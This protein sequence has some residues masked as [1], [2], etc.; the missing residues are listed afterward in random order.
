MQR[1]IGGVEIEGDLAR[2]RPMRLEKQIDEQSVHRLR[3]VADLVVARWFRLR[4]F[5]PVQRRLAGH[6]GAVRAPRPKLPR[7][8]RHQWIVAQRLMVVEVLVAER[9]GEY[10]LPDKRRD[11]MLD[12]GLGSPIDK[13][14][15]QPIHHP[16]RPIR[17]AQQQRPRIRCDRTTV[18][19]RTTWRLRRLQIQKYP[20]YTLSA[21]GLS[22]NHQ[23]VV[24]AKQLSL[25]RSPDALNSV[26]NAG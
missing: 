20:G 7:Q 4:Q 2:R 25:I 19:R 23:E 21:S 11:R 1:I 26:R 5:Q 10:P 22:S 6:C 15:C 8:H 24:L 12:M 17:R 3:I 13:A 14:R 18:K 16:D 9:D